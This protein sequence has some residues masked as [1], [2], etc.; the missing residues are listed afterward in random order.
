MAAPG[1]GVAVEI[2]ACQ[3]T[4]PL[5]RLR[6]LGSRFR[7]GEHGGKFIVQLIITRIADG[8]QQ[9]GTRLFLVL[10][11]IY[12]SASGMYGAQTA[13]SQTKCPIA[14][15]RLDLRYN[16]AGGQSVPQLKLA[17]AN[18]TDKIVSNMTFSLS[19]LD[20]EGNPHPYSENLTYH[21]DIPPGNQQRS[22]TWTLDSA[23]VDMHHTGESMTL[24]DV[25]YSDNSSWKDDGSQACSLTV[26]FH[27]K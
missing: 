5:V 20:S 10:I 16:H 26:D 8:R 19:I 21:R 1:L 13:Q 14:L 12:S 22:H 24:L 6:N 2:H 25:Q 23:S 27:A 9:V 15:N 3:R 11:I 17:F 4:I 18:Q 7:R